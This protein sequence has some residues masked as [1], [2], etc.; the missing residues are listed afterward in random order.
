MLQ[1]EIER[2]DW[3][4][5]ACSLL[6]ATIDKIESLNLK[7]D[8][9]PEEALRTFTRITRQEMRPGDI[10][11]RTG[12]SEL[13]LILPETDITQAEAL[14]REILS[15]LEWYFTISVGVACIP[16]HAAN[17]TSLLE[18]VRAAMEAAV[19]HGGNRVVNLDDTLPG[20][21]GCRGR[22]R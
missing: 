10:I 14:G 2:P 22:L 18:R 13:A 3:R 4:G 21:N 7:S 9:A 1:S 16:V 11:G 17:G 5:H 6:M 19:E 20:A 12:E 8:D 15:V